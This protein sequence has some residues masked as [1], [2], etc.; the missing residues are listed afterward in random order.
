MK[1]R[2]RGRRILW[3]SRDGGGVVADSDSFFLCFAPYA[4]LT[5]EGVFRRKTGYVNFL[6]EEVKRCN[7]NGM[8]AL[9][10]MANMV[11]AF[12]EIGGDGPEG[13][14]GAGS[15]RRSKWE[16]PRTGRIRKTNRGKRLTGSIQSRQQIHYCRD[17]WAETRRQWA[18]C[19]K[20]SIDVQKL[21]WK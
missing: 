19:Q 18:K 15:A 2:W 12:F 10:A 4:K 9:W 17:G 1:D 6:M 21:R 14:G 16:K 3:G 8:F 7:S 13:S 5:C 11:D 20:T